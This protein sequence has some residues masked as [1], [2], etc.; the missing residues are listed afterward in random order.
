MFCLTLK[1][2]DCAAHITQIQGV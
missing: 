1:W 2:V